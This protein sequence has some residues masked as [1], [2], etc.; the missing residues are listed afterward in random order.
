MTAKTGVGYETEA[1]RVRRRLRE[2]LNP[3]ERAAHWWSYH[4]RHVLIA[5]LLLLLALGVWLRSSAVVPAD[6]SV[7]WVGREPL[8][9]ET[10][11]QIAQA[12]AGYGEDINGD[13]T[14]HVEVHQITLDLENLLDHGVQGQQ[15]YGAVMA[16]EADLST[17]QSGLF[18]TDDPAALQA[19]TGALLY[20][21]GSE[22][23][24]GAEDWERMAVSWAEL[25]IAQAAP[26]GEGLY[27]AC[28]GCWQAE[29]EERFGQSWALWQKL[30]Q[31]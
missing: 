17:F 31:E 18:L 20:L 22:P 12:L 27:L 16:L 8:E 11:R 19:Y 10:A 15:A 9:E 29:Q 3:R 30:L 1:D 25:P 28:R 7:A 13:G 21:D 14:V 24:E 2:T 5:A 26:E 23:P 6:Y 4:R